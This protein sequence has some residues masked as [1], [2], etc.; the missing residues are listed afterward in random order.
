MLIPGTCAGYTPSGIEM[1]VDNKVP[2][3]SVFVMRTKKTKVGGHIQTLGIS[4]ETLTSIRS[5]E[6]EYDALC[7]L[8]ELEVDGPMVRAVV[9]DAGP[10]RKILD[11]ERASRS[12]AIEAAAD[13]L[14]RE[15]ESF[16]QRVGEMRARPTQRQA[17]VL[18][19]QLGE[20]RD[21][22]AMLSSVIQQTSEL[23]EFAA[24][25]LVDT[26]ELSR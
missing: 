8:D 9:K 18:G 21:R 10:F 25:A 24:V 22:H 15:V 20:L 14:K 7:Q 11:G 5:S 2:H 16:V 3:M 1:V 13:E 6:Y 17:E 23:L 26:T 4:E 12:D 19:G